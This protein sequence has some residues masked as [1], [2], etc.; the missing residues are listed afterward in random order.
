MLYIYLLQIMLSNFTIQLQ[1]PKLF[2]TVVRGISQKDQ[3]YAWIIILACVT[4]SILIACGLSI[5]GIMIIELE[6][7][8]QASPVELNMAATTQF[9]IHLFSG[10]LCFD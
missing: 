2:D 10:K 4:T 7:T 8:F 1:W 6:N 3:G 5:S 9:P